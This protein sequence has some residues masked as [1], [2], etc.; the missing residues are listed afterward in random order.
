MNPR[1]AQN[2]AALQALPRTKTLLFQRQKCYQSHHPQIL[3]PGWSGG[4]REHSALQRACRPYEV[5]MAGTALVALALPSRCSDR[6]DTKRRAADSTPWL[7]PE[8]FSR[9]PAC[10]THSPSLYCKND[11]INTFGRS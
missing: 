7:A 1:C 3:S 8:L 11:N 5:C 2:A 4:A 6:R 9:Q 10:L